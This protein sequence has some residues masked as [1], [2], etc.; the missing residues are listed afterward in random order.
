MAQAKAMGISSAWSRSPKITQ[1]RASSNPLLKVVCGQWD[2]ED[3][4]ALQEGDST[5]DRDG[6][7]T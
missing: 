4:E 7:V 1:G 3:G 2:W 6:E 5:K